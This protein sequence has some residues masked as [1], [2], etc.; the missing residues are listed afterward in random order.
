MSTTTDSLPATAGPVVL[1]GTPIVPGVALGPVIRPAGAVQLPAE[2]QPP[3]AEGARPGEKERFAA[4]AKAVAERLGRRAA[5]ATGVSAEVLTATAGLARDRGL[6][7]AVEQRIDAGTPA[8]VATMQAAQHFVDLFTSMGGLMAE[9]ATDVRDVRDRLVAE[10]TGQGEPG[11]PIPDEPSVLLADDLAP[12]APAGRH[13]ARVVA[14]AP[15]R[16][17][18]TSHTAIIARQLGLPCVVAVGGLDD[19]PAGAT[20]LLDGEQG[21]VTVDPDPAEAQAR[22]RAARIAAQALSG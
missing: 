2:D 8:A 22:V 17:G 7:S 6:L 4:A 3:L 12:P 15:R 1:T 14:L 19:V 13:P 20:V 11:V 21:T 5:A 9:R 16:G 18:T 10:L